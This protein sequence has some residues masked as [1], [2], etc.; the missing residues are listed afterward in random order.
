MRKMHAAIYLRSVQ[1]ITF[2]RDRDTFTVSHVHKLTTLTKRE[3]H[4]AIDRLLEAKAIKLVGKYKIQGKGNLVSH[5]T[6]CDN[7]ISQL[8]KV[9][10]FVVE[11]VVN[12][13]Q[14]KE[15]VQLLPDVE[16]QE[17]NTINEQQELIAPPEDQKKDRED[18][19]C[20]LKVV[21]KANVTGMG[22]MH[23]KH[24]DQLLAGVRA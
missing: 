7:A 19:A 18:F 15:T 5:Y 9:R 17:I 23:L 20:E 24:L 22:C 6:V 12:L 2:V 3:A 13:G 16:I 11:P 14:I 1:V 21:K 4:T 8:R 10:G